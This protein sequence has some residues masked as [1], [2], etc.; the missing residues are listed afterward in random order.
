MCME[1][2]CGCLVPLFSCN[3]WK[4]T[5]IEGIGNAKTN[6]HFLQ[7]V[8]S[9]FNGSQCGFCSP[10]MVMNMYSLFQNKQLTMKEVENSFGGN[11]CRCTGY[12]PIL[13]AF[14]SICKDASPDLMGK[15]SDIEDLKICQKNCDKPCSNKYSNPHYFNLG[16]ATWIKVFL[17]NDLLQILK[18][19]HNSTYMLVAGNTSFGVY[20]ST[21]EYQVY[22]DITSIEELITYKVENDFLIMGANMSLTEAMTLF[23]K[24]A[25][26]Y[27]KLTYLKRLSS[28]IDLIA[29]VPVRN[30]GTLAGNLMMKHDHHDFP[31]DIFLILETVGAVLLIVDAE[32]NRTKISIKDLLNHSMKCKVI[33]KII[34]PPR[35]SGFKFD[36][37]KIM[38]RAQNA[39]ALVNAGFLL[40]LNE[41]NIVKSARIVYG[42]I[43]PSFIHATKTEQFL[44]GKQLFEDEVLQKSFKVLESELIP[45]IIL[46]E[47]SP[48]FRKQLAISLFYKYILS[49]TPKNLISPRNRSGA[50]KLERPV[51]SGVQDFETKAFMYPV[52]KPI[53]KIESL[54]QTSGQAEYIMD[55]PDL[56]NQLFGAFVLAKTKSLSIIRKI[57]TSE[58]FKLDGVI[59]FFDKN[60]IPGQNNF[61]PK[62]AHLPIKEEIFCSGEVQYFNQPVGLIVATSQEVAEKAAN[63]VNITYVSGANQPL[64]TIKDI[65]KFGGDERVNLEN[66]VKP[67]RKGDK[68]KHVVKGS[69]ELSWQYHF[70]MET[71]C[72]NVVPTEDGLDIYPS[73]QWL[74]L[75]QTAAATTLNIPANKINISVRRLGGGFGG[76]IIRN[77]LISCAAGIAA[78]KLQ[79][80]VKIWMPFETNMNVIGK[81]YPVVCNYEVGVSDEGIIQ[82]LNNTFYSDYGRGGN[83]PNI[84]FVLETFLGNYNTD[85]WHVKAYSTK[86][87]N[88]PSCY[89]RAP[90]TCEGLGMIE[91][92]ME[93]VAMFL[94]MDGT[95]FRLKNL[96][97]ERHELLVKF[98]SDLNK[99]AEIDIRKQEIYKFNKDNKWKKKGI[100]V[101][102]MMFPFQLF[103]NYGVIIS[104]YQSDG[105]VSI[106][107]GGVEMGQG[108]NTKAAQV[109]SY[110]LGIPV[111]KISVK[112]SNN[113][114][115][116]NAI[117]SGGSVTSETVCNGVIKACDIL[118]KRMEPIKNEL[119]NASWEELVKKCH[120]EFI[121]LSASSIAGPKEPGIE[122]YNIYGVCAAEIELDVLT[123]QHLLIR[124]DLLEDAGTSTNP[125]ID[126]GQVEGAFVMGVGYYTSEQIVFNENGELLTNRTWN[127]KPPGAKDIPVDFRIKFPRNTPNQVGVLHSKAIAEPPLCLACAV[128][129]AIRNAVASVRVESGSSN[130]KWYPF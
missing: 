12:R 8:L 5:T 65:L 130:E 77:S 41:K 50:C 93:H 94:G 37:Y 78:Y 67:K 123:G 115:A 82:Y 32:G 10:G 60:D 64:L 49:I 79:K 34:L 100:S 92:I 22:V 105:T 121:N 112:P 125:S 126:M 84:P 76:K 56:S 109:C 127:Y 114:I 117:M 124:V 99:W 70:H 74:D 40:E 91:A 104:I 97:K 88:H 27:E 101:V 43:N 16:K 25:E 21:V 102:P 98:I 30:L 120:S 51:S 110:K 48:I 1:G 11:I 87:D 59:A 31:S 29:N 33:E 119:K 113:L 36:S 39:H 52:T 89:T 90:G 61:T 68:I 7:K 47:P 18:T 6:Y 107:H 116:P 80:P 128:P 86:T 46:P 103:G 45:N 72:C 62:E 2:G 23:D 57:D 44:V 63:L 122:N 108:I 81:R 42:T 73:S 55:M 96:D 15:Y 4:I 71:Q 69:F 95:E 19:F 106:A 28:H 58:A 3:G 24:L 13:S 14:K 129:L 75:S 17:L 9:Y 54:A 85:T 118:I 53:S 38:P 83:E 20:R 26:K 66:E 35:S 111:E